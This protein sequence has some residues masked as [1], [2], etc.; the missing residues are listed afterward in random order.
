MLCLVLHG[1]IAADTF[2]RDDLFA[3]ARGIGDDDVID[4]CLELTVFVLD[5]DDR[6][7]YDEVTV[8]P[9]LFFDH[10]FFT[11]VL[12]TDVD[13]PTRESRRES[14]VLSFFTDRQRQLLVVHDDRRDSLFLVQ[15]DFAHA[16]GLEG[17]L[18]E[19]DRIVT[20]GHDVN[21]FATQ[22][23]GDVAHARSPRAHARA[24]GVDHGVV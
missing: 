7:V 14:S 22:L 5:H 20:V 15:L 16:R 24:D 8:G 9:D 4:H 10:V 3:V 6:L 1:L 18:D 13:A 23:V 2:D 17:R 12:R 21:S 19:L 11:L